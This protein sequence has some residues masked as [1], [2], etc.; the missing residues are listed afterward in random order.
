MQNSPGGS[1]PISA[2]VSCLRD[3][4]CTAQGVQS[5][6]MAHPQGRERA[7]PLLF[8]RARCSVAEGDGG[9]TERGTNS[10]LQ[11]SAVGK[12]CVGNGEIGGLDRGGLVSFYRGSDDQVHACTEGLRAKNYC[13][14]VVSS[15][16]KRKR[17]F[18]AQDI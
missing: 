3:K 1:A 7:R 9:C 6:W 16:K 15:E 14:S 17:A 11:G 18:Q 4:S 12:V 10:V 5:D 13:A 8:F 2:G